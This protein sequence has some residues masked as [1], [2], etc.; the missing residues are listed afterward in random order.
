MNKRRLIM[1][2]RRIAATFGEQMRT[3]YRQYIAEGGTLPVKMDELYAF[4]S[5][6]G[7][8]KPQKADLRKQFGKQMSRALRED[9]FKDAKGRT[10][11]KHHAVVIPGRDAEG[12]DVQ[13]VLWDDI[14]TAPRE[15]LEGAF[16]LRRGQ[17]VGDC[18]QLKNDVDYVNDTRLTENPIPML[19]D[20]T[21]DVEEASLPTEYVPDSDDVNPE[22]VG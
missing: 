19:W 3:I 9:Y 5:K 18:K 17:I 22:V 1:P 21:D 10:V 7:L 12:N 16:Q 20:F 2:K 6:N 4:A 11:R 14:D 15:H 13:Q 8:W